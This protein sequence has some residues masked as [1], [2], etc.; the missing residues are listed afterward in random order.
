MKP[1]F[2]VAENGFPAAARE[3]IVKQALY[4]VLKDIDEVNRLYP[5]VFAQREY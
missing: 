2:P 4:E 3:Q 5:I 1:Q